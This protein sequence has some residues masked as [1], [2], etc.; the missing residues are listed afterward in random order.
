M[1]KFENKQDIIFFT[2]LTCNTNNFL[3]HRASTFLTKKSV[4]SYITIC[5]HCHK[6]NH[7]TW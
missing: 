1:S 2:S 5:V 6:K 7:L 3:S 4:T